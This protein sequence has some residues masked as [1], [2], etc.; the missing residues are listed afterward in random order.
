MTKKEL[1]TLIKIANELYDNKPS[2]ER[3]Y[4]YETGKY[5]YEDSDFSK[6]LE[7]LYKFIEERSNHDNR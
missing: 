2:S 6:A 3:S 7:K 1:A 4:D 5:I